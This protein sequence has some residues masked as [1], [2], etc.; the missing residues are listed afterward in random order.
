MTKDKS[1]D[2][3][4][5]LLNV[6]RIVSA[7]KSG[8][9]GR[10]VNNCALMA[11]VPLHVPVIVT[12][13]TETII[14]MQKIRKRPMGKEE[15]VQEDKHA[16]KR[17]SMARKNSFAPSVWVTAIVLLGMELFF[18]SKTFLTVFLFSSI[19]VV[20]HCYEYPDT[21]QGCWNISSLNCDRIF[22]TV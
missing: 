2:G 16:S 18:L 3:V 22:I 8:G 13:T 4:K 6:P 21:I 19:L 1:M 14:E 15:I 7:Q 5:I 12:A 20:L 10:H 17:M 9:W 11:D